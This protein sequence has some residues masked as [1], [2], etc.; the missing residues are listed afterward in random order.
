MEY[1]IQYLQPFDPWEHRLETPYVYKGFQ[2]ITI[3]KPIPGFA[4]A[5]IIMNNTFY[6]TSL[7][8]N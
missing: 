5:V 6:I 1:P 4:H 2:R 3:R 8:L 7:G